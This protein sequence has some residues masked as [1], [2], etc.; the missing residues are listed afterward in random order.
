MYLMMRKHDFPGT[1]N[2]EHY[3]P[4]GDVQPIRRPHIELLSQ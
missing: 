1:N 3:V 4:V 2:V